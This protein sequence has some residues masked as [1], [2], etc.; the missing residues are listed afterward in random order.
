[1]S[2]PHNISTQMLVDCGAPSSM[3]D[4]CGWRGVDDP[5]EKGCG[6]GNAHMVY[7]YYRNH[8]AYTAE[9]YPYTSGDS[10]LPGSTCYTPTDNG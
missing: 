10:G 1:M 9:S 5:V 7:E 6:G 2:T 8:I 3:P 4:Y